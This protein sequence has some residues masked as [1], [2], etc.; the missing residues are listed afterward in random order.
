MTGSDG[1]PLQTFKFLRT[2]L[3]ED[4]VI[5]VREKQRPNAEEIA[6]LG[7][8]ATRPV[9][10]DNPQ[11]NETWV[12]YK[13]VDSFFASGPRSRH[14]TLDYISGI[15]QFG[16]SAMDASAARAG[17]AVQQDKDSSYSGFYIPP[18]K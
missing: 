15:V 14:Y 17:L 11:S 2:P 8:D 6:D 13:R 16:G 1:S 9:T 4:E 3:L 7:P 18:D 10:P 5:E 12:R